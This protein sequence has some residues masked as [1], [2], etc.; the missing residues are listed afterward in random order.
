MS[1]ALREPACSYTMSMSDARAHHRSRWRLSPVG[2]VLAV[3]LVVLLLLAIF[4]S[5]KYVIIGLI[6][7]V[8][9]WAAVLSSSFPSM[10]GRRQLPGMPNEDFGREAADEYEREHGYGH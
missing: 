9:L 5:N 7:V 1:P 10:A 4:D 3:A 6:V 2:V 8:L